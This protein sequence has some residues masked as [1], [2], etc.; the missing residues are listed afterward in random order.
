VNANYGF[1][2]ERNFPEVRF[3]KGFHKD[4]FFLIPGKNENI[5]NKRVIRF[6]NFGVPNNYGQNSFFLLGLL[7]TA[8]SEAVEIEV[9]G[10]SKDKKT[11]GGWSNPII[12]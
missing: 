9:I 7:T 3:C 5:E 1:C 11:P 12:K 2:R 8:R 10:F 4:C 6:I